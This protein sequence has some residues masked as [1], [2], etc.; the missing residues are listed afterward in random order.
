M[1]FLG[2]FWYLFLVLF[3]TITLLIIFLFINKDNSYSNTDTSRETNFFVYAKENNIIYWDKDKDIKKVLSDE[4]LT[5]DDSYYM[6]YLYSLSHDETKLIFTDNYDDNL[7]DLKYV[8]LDNLNNEEELD[9]TLIATSV[10]DAE[11]VYNGI[12][13]LYENDLYYFDYDNAN[14]IFEN[15]DM[16]DVSEDGKSIYFLDKNE[17]LYKKEL[18]NNKIEKINSSVYSMFEL[19]NHILSITKNEHNNSY[20]LYYDNELVTNSFLSLNSYSIK[21]NEFYFGKYEGTLT[22]DDSSINYTNDLSDLISTDDGYQILI[23]GQEGCKYTTDLLEEFSSLNNEYTIRYNYLDIN[24]LS[25]EDINYIE[26]IVGSITGTPTTVILKDDELV[27]S[28]DGYIDYYELWDKLYDYIELEYNDYEYFDDAATY[29]YKDGVLTRV[30]DGMLYFDEDDNSQKIGDVGIVYNNP[31][32]E[33]VK[34]YFYDTRRDKK[35]DTGI[36]NGTI[37]Y[38]NSYNNYLVYSNDS[39]YYAMSYSNGKKSNLKKLGTDICY[40]DFYKGNL[41][42][43]NECDDDYIGTLTVLNDDEKSVISDYV[44]EFYFNKDRVFYINEDNELY[45]YLDNGKT[46]L[47]DSDVEYVQELNDVLYYF[48]DNDLDEDTYYYDCYYISEDNKKIRVDSDID[49]GLFIN[50]TRNSF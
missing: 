4:Y 49:I 47:I 19:N 2:K 32:S 5:N 50:I 18:K 24:E 27:T 48:V 11:I 39:S 40:V 38:F 3:I 42:Y 28:F 12:I 37:E 15:V 33:D 7:F 26:S 6:S 21:D 10:E 44:S 41:Y 14:L 43:L 1:K 29:R 36:K 20:E 45:Y 30:V 46:K 25:Y 22:T 9:I 31:Y 16:Y 23:F 34:Y 17:D 35:I 13:Y 8:S